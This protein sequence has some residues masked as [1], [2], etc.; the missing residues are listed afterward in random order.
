MAVDACRIHEGFPTPDTLE[1]PHGLLVFVTGLSPC[2][3]LLSRRLHEN[4][5]PMRGSPNTTLPVRASVWAASPSLAVT[6]DIAL[7]FLFLPVLRC[8]NSRRSPLRE[9][10]AV[11]IPIRISYV[12][13]LH[14]APVGLSQLGTSFIGFR[15][16]PSTS[17][18]SSQLLDTSNVVTRMNE[19]SGRLDRTY[20]RFHMQP[21]WSNWAHRPFPSALA[22]DGAS[23]LR[24]HSKRRHPLKGSGFDWFGT[25]THWD[26]NP[27][28]PPCKGGALPLSYGPDVRSAGVS[29]GSS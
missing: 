28:L 29:L 2:I 12:L 16:E 11:G 10:I 17:W 22:R 15:A 14:A 8:F 26:L 6:N 7:R 18:H 19:S 25:W 1:L 5:R 20:T 23:V 27:G 24:N 21:K 9:A 3:A 4:G 13:R